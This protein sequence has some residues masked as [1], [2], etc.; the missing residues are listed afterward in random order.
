MA[1]WQKFDSP[2][3]AWLHR[4]IMHHRDEDIPKRAF[5]PYFSPEVVAAAAAAMRRG[6]EVRELTVL[7]SNIRGFT[8]VSERLEPRQVVEQFNAGFT[9]MTESVFKHGGIIDKFIGDGMMV[10][11]NAPLERPDHALR[12]VQTALELQERTRDMSR[13]F[14]RAIHCGVGIST[15]NAFVGNIG[16]TQRMQYGAV[17]YTVDLASRLEA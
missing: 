10:L 5:Q 11:Y 16:S 17:G 3:A 1:W 2:A 12:A 9:A 7:Y 8:S 4:V 13:R 6:G 15:G 14:G